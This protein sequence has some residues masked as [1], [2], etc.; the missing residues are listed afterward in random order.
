M[1]TIWNCKKN[2]EVDSKSSVSSKTLLESPKIVDIPTNLKEVVCD[3]FTCD[4][5]VEN[6]INKTKTLL[7]K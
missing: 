4:E 7:R 3:N 6:I 2:K 5:N 1:S